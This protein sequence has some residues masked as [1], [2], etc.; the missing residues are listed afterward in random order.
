M[1]GQLLAFNPTV[2]GVDREAE[3]TGDLVD[4]IPA[5]LGRFVA[6]FDLG[7][8]VIVT[9]S[10]IDNGL[11]SACPEVGYSWYAGIKGNQSHCSCKRLAC[12]PGESSNTR[13]WRA[14][15]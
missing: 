6:G 3:V 13:R 2:D 15:Y 10:R 11:G 8:S 9:E 5:R 7:H 12:N 14:G 1:G 4:G